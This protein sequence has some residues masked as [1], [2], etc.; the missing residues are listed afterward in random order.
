MED[1]SKLLEM[2]GALPEE[3]WWSRDWLILALVAQHHS[4]S[5]RFTREKSKNS[6]RSIARMFRLGLRK[7][8]GTFWSDWERLKG[9]RSE[10]PCSW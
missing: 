3:D 9:T 10:A 2:W 8:F 1:P 6:P 4:R 7:E 5:A